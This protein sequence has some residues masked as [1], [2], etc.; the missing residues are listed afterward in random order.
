[1][2]KTAVVGKAAIHLLLQGVFLVVLVLLVSTW[3][4]SATAQE[5]PALGIDAQPV[6][7]TAT[8]LEA[9][10]R[11]VS[12]ASGDSF[13]VDITISAATQLLAW[14]TYFKYE[15][16]ALRVVGVD[17]E[18]FQAANQNSNVFNASDPVPDLDGLYRVTAADLGEPNAA[19]TGSGV[20]AR[21]TLEAAL[22]G[23]HSISIAAIDRN[24]DGKPDIGPTLTND[25]GDHPGDS[26]G[27]GFYDRDIADAVVA[28]DQPCGANS[29][30]PG[31]V[32]GSASGGSD[33]AWWIALPIGLGVATVLVAGGVVLK[34]VRRRRPSQA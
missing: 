18:M 5:E 9:V 10:D 28:V 22:P 25:A 17:V 1:M 20:L 31:G 32:E 6:G 11:C 2:K 27:D 4:T 23:V 24:G 30:S 8:S 33:V 7:N 26:N 13:D 29:G 14:E 21:L 34:A 16:R 19:D 12:V 3:A 15:A